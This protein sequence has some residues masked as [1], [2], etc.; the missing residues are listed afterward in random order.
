M[1]I[2][3]NQLRTP[4][5]TVLTSRR[6]HDFVEHT[7]KNGRTYYIDGGLDYVRGTA[8]GDEEYMTTYISFRHSENRANAFWGTRG[9]DGKQ[10]L[11][12][13]PI[14]DMETAHIELVLKECNP[15][16]NIK[17]VMEQELL[18]RSS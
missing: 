1:K 6:R 11:D 4:D 2:L 17:Y 16:D 10:P 7:D 9:V 3:L 12:F 18:F 14:K 13:I 15:H 8:H 5:G